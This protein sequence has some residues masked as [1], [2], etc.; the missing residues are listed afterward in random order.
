MV[1]PALAAAFFLNR[2]PR[3]A[4]CF[5]LLLWFQALR[6]KCEGWWERIE[7]ED[8]VREQRGSDFG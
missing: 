1:G 7:L 6:S 3:P 4:L 2:D 8:E 5:P